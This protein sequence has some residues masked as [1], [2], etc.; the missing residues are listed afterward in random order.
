V[1]GLVSCG[2]R[3]LHWNE[4]VDVFVMLELCFIMGDI[5]SRSGE[6]TGFFEVRGV[7]RYCFDCLSG[8]VRALY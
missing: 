1:L 4:A 2:V 3:V 5:L 7:H 8:C 6:Y